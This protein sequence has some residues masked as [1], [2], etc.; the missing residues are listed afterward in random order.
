LPRQRLARRPAPFPGA[1]L[2][3]LIVWLV[4]RGDSHETHAHG[5]EALNFQISMFIYNCIAA[6]FLPHRR[7]S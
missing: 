3:R 1:L 4:K 7:S 5:K 6:V 2:G